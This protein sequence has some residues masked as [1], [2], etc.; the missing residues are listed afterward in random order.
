MNNIVA[1]ERMLRDN[2]YNIIRLKNV[3]SIEGQKEHQEFVKQR[4]RIKE[5]LLIAYREEFQ[6]MIMEGSYGKVSSGS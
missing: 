3:S 1:L 5:R 4:A 6:Q 2:K